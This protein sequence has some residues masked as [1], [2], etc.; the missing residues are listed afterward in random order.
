MVVYL[1][2]EAGDELLCLIAGDAPKGAEFCR[3]GEATFCSG[4]DKDFPCASVLGCPISNLELRRVL[5]CGAVVQLLVYAAM[6]VPVD[7][8]LSSAFD[9]QYAAAL[10]K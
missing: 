5:S 3:V 4:D 6:Q 7:L 1:N 2:P 8:T 10:A 9:A